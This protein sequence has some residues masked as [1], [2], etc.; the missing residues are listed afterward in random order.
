MSEAVRAGTV[1]FPSAEKNMYPTAA[2][3]AETEEG[4]EM[5]FSRWMKA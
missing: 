4:A 1:T 2:L 3:T 5:L